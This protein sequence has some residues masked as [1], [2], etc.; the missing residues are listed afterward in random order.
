MKPFKIPAKP[1]YLIRHGETVANVAKIT[2]GGGTDSP[3]TDWGRQQAQT[4]GNI[5][6]KLE[7]KPTKI[8]HSPM[9]RARDTA[10]YL[11]KA[12][13]L[14]MHEINDLRE[15]LVGEWEGDPWED[16]MP[17]LKANIR[18]EGGENKDDFSMRVQKTMT[19][20]LDASHEDPVMIVAHGGTFF[21]L[22]HLYEQQYENH[23]DNCHLHYFEPYPDRKDFPWQV[24]QFDVEEDALRK[25]NAPFCGTIKL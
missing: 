24:W 6:H 7:I 13:S 25:S 12:L 21:S 5:I 10:S 9:V 20:I 22:F 18:P 4:L 3:L 23:I 8:F 1:F 16:V 19:E 15:H 14:A 2:A 11:N 17:K